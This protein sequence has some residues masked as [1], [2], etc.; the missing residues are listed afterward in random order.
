MIDHPVHPGEILLEELLE[1]GFIPDDFAQQFGFDPK[2]FLLICEQSSP[3][4]RE[5]AQNLAESLGT[6][7]D[8]WTNLQSAYNRSRNIGEVCPDKE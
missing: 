8:L 6:T 1:R 4:T 5:M 3:V 7:V 2:E